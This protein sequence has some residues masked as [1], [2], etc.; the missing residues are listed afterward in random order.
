MP[1]R[2]EGFCKLSVYFR[3]FFPFSVSPE[4][5]E[6]QAMYLPNSGRLHTGEGN[7]PVSIKNIEC[8]QRPLCL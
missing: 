8:Y 6:T 5:L 7:P 1:F 2:V 4:T 3:R